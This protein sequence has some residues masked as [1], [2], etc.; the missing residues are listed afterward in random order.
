M[1]PCICHVDMLGR[2]IKRYTE[3]STRHY[4]PTNAYGM[5]AND[6]DGNGNLTISYSHLPVP[7]GFARRSLTKHD[8]DP[9][10][11]AYYHTGAEGNVDLLSGDNGLKTT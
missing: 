8:W 2:R 5:P 11:T 6:Y 1:V 7:G 10:F 3:N 4:L 9:A